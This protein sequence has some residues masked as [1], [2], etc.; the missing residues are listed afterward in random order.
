MRAQAVHSGMRWGIGAICV[1]ALIATVSALACTP[2]TSHGGP[3]RDHVSLVDN[4]RAR[5]LRVEPVAQIALPLLSV[6]GTQLSASGS[7]L[8]TP[9]A[10]LRS[11]DYNDTDLG[12]D[13]RRAADEDAGRISA[14]GRSAALPGGRVSTTFGGTPHFYRRERV[15]VLYVGDDGAVLTL[16]RELLGPQFAGG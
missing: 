14:D 11:F 3:V 6:P 10:E 7:A 15:I 5:G 16:L 4:L 8:A 9:A 1:S 13:G 2:P 12:R